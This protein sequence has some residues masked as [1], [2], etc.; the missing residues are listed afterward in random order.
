M[1]LKNSLLL[2]VALLNLMIGFYVYSKN[3]KS[4]LR[5]SFL[6]LTIGVTLWILSITLS[7]NFRILIYSLFWST[8]FNYIAA[9]FI[10]FSFLWLTKL[11]PFERQLSSKK[12]VVLFLPFLLLLITLIFYPSF[13]ITRVN[14][15][16]GSYDAIY[17]IYGY[18]IFSFYFLFYMG[19]GFYN[20]IKNYLLLEGVLKNNIKLLIIGLGIGAILG[21]IFDLILPFF[22][23]WSLIWLGPYF[24]LVMVFCVAYMMMKKY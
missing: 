15:K 7:N 2:V 13:I 14:F 3:W 20:L 11:F 5:L 19:L 6:L 23:Y 10:A 1:D 16:P 18:S 21:I 12:L 22:N 17:N 9:G 8:S 24:S 4:Q